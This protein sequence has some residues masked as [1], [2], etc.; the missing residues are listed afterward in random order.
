MN[1]RDAGLPGGRRPTVGFL[2]TGWIGRAR[3]AS[4]VESGRAEVVGVADPSPRA[5]AAAL[6]LA[7]GA[8]ALPELGALLELQPD[9]VVIASP[10]ALHAGQVGRALRHGAAVFCQKPLGRSEA[11]ARLLVDTARRN[12]RL[13]HVDLSYR[14]VGGIPALRELVHEGGIG[15]VFAVDLTFHNAWGPEG[16]WFYSRR[17]AGGGCLLDLGTH[18]VDLALWVLDH[19]EPRSVRAHLFREGRPLDPSGDGVED[20]A[21]AEVE[22]GD[23]V[24]LRLSCS[25]NLSAGRDAVIQADFHGTEGGASLRNVDGSFYDFGVE[26]YSG[27]HRS[28]LVE[29]GGVA[30]TSWGGGAILQWVDRLRRG[31]FYDRSVEEILPVTRLLDRMY[32]Q[33]GA[34]TSPSAPV[35]SEGPLLLRGGG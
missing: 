15:R 8:A 25:W 9:G 27:T 31:G 14:H 23:G 1:S 32:R 34:S 20:F 4:V 16:E 29:G 22:L 17:Q 26:R 12:D 5:R 7:P 35:R 13:L 2:G 24:L 11:E 18:L 28:S 3:L 19:P 30:P 10:S 6:E 33:G 21:A